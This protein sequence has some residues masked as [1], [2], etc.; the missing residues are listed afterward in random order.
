M[1]SHRLKLS[2]AILVC[3]FTLIFHELT[4][5]QVTYGTNPDELSVVGNTTYTLLI[6]NL[7]WN[8]S[9]IVNSHAFENR[10][11]PEFRPT[12]GA[13]GTGTVEVG[14]IAPRLKGDNSNVSNAVI[15]ACLATFESGTPT[16]REVAK[17]GTTFVN[18]GESKTRNSLQLEALYLK[19]V[20]RLHN[21]EHSTSNSSNLLSV[22]AVPEG[23]VSGVWSFGP[24]KRSLVGANESNSNYD[25]ANLPPNSSVEM[26][27]EERTMDASASEYAALIPVELSVGTST[28]IQSHLFQNVALAGL[29]GVTVLTIYRWFGGRRYRLIAAVATGLTGVVI[30]NIYTSELADPGSGSNNT[31]IVPLRPGTS[32]PP[33][34]SSPLDHDPQSLMMY[35]KVTGDVT[36]RSIKMPG[37]AGPIVFKPNTIE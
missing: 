34:T 3:L 25:I 36:L 12:I 21:S 4:L 9:E 30:I 13:S 5:A 37:I 24:F 16:Y 18:D 19:E 33:P 7:N 23:S 15:Y 17:Y 27:G 20:S 2:N 6:N 1:K 32:P 8:S 11:P 35:L 14:L 22:S 26:T 10:N 31:R 28:S 29:A